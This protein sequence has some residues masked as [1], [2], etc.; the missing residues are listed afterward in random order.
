MLELNFESLSSTIDKL[1][2]IFNLL[3]EFSPEFPTVSGQV[4]RFVKWMRE[5]K[6]LADITAHRHY[7]YLRSVANYM[8]DQYDL[9]N[10][11]LKSTRPTYTKKPRRYFSPSEIALAIRACTTDDDRALIMTLIDSGCR[12]QDL[13]G[14]K[15]NQIN[16]NSFTTSHDKK[17]GSHTYRLD[18]QLCQVLK[19]L[20]GSD[21]AYI[22]KCHT[23]NQFHKNDPNAP[24]SPTALSNRVNYVLRRA[25]F[26]GTKLH[27]HTFR[28]SAGSIIAKYTKSALA[29]KS[30]LGH[31]DIETSMIYIHDA[32][33][34][35]AQEVSPLHIIADSLSFDPNAPVKQTELLQSPD[36]HNSTDIIPIDNEPSPIDTLIAESYPLPPEET[37][38]TTRLHYDEILL[39]RRAFMAL[40][41]GT[42]AIDDPMKS[43]ILWKRMFRKVKT[44]VFTTNSD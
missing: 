31:S 10:P 19:R 5:E 42:S 41:N 27:A 36:N 8:S 43:R 23:N 11:F 15:A 29:V 7:T 3:N 35:I 28:H 9:P 4:N 21:N 18:P 32:E 22:F 34:E 2:E 13:S 17:T 30:V 37:T 12:I 40:C 14:L 24:A 33:Q 25:G 16:H 39:L 1:R 38:I 44:N 20:A 6:N 26:K